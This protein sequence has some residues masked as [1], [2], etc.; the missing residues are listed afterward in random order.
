MGTY[1]S[2][3]KIS[4]G[5]LGHGGTSQTPAAFVLLLPPRG[6]VAG[7]PDT[8]FA[9]GEAST[10]GTLALAS[11]YRAG[12]ESSLG[13]GSG[14]VSLHVASETK[15]VLEATV[16]PNPK[17]CHRTAVNPNPIQAPRELM[18]AA[19]TTLA[20]YGR[21]HWME[22]MH[23]YRAHNRNARCTLHRTVNPNP[24]V[25]HRLPTRYLLG[26]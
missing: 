5:L 6:R 17:H 3:Y 25:K 1:K 20:G 10:E 23:P 12:L 18:L 15:L 19:V 16:N 21:V 26:G 14:R 2:S 22:E 4:P 9:P 11:A 24:T 7:M 13:E 8:P